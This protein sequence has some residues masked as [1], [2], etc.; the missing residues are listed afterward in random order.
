MSRMADTSTICSPVTGI[1]SSKK[2]LKVLSTRTRRIF[3]LQITSKVQPIKHINQHSKNLAQLN[4]MEIY[5][6]IF[7]NSCNR[8]IKN[9]VHRSSNYCSS[10]YSSNK[11]NKPEII[12]RALR[13]KIE[14][15][16]LQQIHKTTIIGQFI[17]ARKDHRMFHTISYTT[18]IY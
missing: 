17:V 8:K 15:K 13:A 16:S 18:K 12:W 7:F 14:C 11:I 4:L 10:K 1:T 2:K 9:L 5:H 6:P 3:N